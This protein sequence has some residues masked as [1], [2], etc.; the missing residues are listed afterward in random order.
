[1]LYRFFF[2]IPTNRVKKGDIILAG[3]KPKYVLEAE[4]NRITA[5]NYETSVIENILPER[6]L[7]LGNTYFYGKLVSMFGSKGSN[8]KKGTGKI[9]KYMMLGQMLK[10]GGKSD[11]MPLLFLTGGK[12]GCM[13]DLFEL[14]LDDETD[15]G[16]EEN[17]E[18][19]E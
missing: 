1:M 13:D 7:F 14:D 12:N 8:G 4:K 2:V 11:L 5:L 17:T 9:L 15:D 18:E 10:G 16:P 6:Y 3:G 19:D